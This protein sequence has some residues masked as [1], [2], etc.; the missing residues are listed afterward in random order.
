TPAVRLGPREIVRPD[1]HDRHLAA[2]EALDVVTPEAL[3]RALEEAEFRLFL[4]PVVDLA[5][6][7]V[8]G[9]E[10]L[11]RWQHTTRGLLSPAEFLAVAEGGGVIRA[12]GDWVIGEACRL[13]RRC[14][15]E[16]HD[17]SFSI[18]ANVSVSQLGDASFGDRVIDNLE[19]AGLDARRLHIEVT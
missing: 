8:R 16:G 1:P 6:E 11:L 5:D 10:A 4:Q 19:R 2:I 13:G 9:A 3:L 7:R 12:V 15:D 14:V 17:L 18:S